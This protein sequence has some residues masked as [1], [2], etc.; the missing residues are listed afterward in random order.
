MHWWEPVQGDCGGQGT[1]KWKGAERS[2]SRWGCV[3]RP[4]G[5]PTRSTLE[6]A[7]QPNACN[8]YK[9]EDLLRKRG[10]NDSQIWFFNP[11][12]CN[13]W[14]VSLC[15]YVMCTWALCWWLPTQIMGPTTS[16]SLSLS[17]SLTDLQSW[18]SGWLLAV[19]STFMVKTELGIAWLESGSIKLVQSAWHFAEFHCF[20]SPCLYFSFWDMKNGFV[21][22]CHVEGRFNNCLK[23]LV[24]SWSN[25]IL[26]V[27]SCEWQENRNLNLSSSQNLSM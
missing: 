20:Y 23:K 15:V 17:H 19:Q 25:P 26:S 7:L 4:C 6:G 9:A 1:G 22:W 11:T 14:C 13:F 2:E 27:L 3:P 8:P 21:L 5:K 10:S 16:L 18:P 24:S 12:F